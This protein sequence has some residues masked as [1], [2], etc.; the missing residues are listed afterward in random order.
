MRRTFSGLLALGLTAGAMVAL[1]GGIAAAS[2]PPVVA[3]TYQSLAMNGLLS[4]GSPVLLT[5][6]TDTNSPSTPYTA[7]LVSGPSHANAQGAFRWGGDGSFFY[8]PDQNF[9][10]VDS[11]TFTVTDSSGYTSNPA[12]AY[13]EVGYF[14]MTT[15]LPDA[16]RGVPYSATLSA[17]GGTMP[18]RWGRTGKLPPGLRLYPLT[19]VI[20]GTPRLCPKRL[21]PCPTTVYTVLFKVKDSSRPRA[22][23][24]ATLTLT[25]H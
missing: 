20:S 1:G 3:D 8:Q 2:S 11:F 6:V 12:T 24:T 13:L 22:L 19:G 7:T 14:I 18:E 4:A 15:S 23:R 21:A 25:L 5:G 17:P 16:T 10:G 9:V